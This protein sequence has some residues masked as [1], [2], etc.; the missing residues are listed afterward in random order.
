LGQTR[1]AV[2]IFETNCASIDELLASAAVGA[3]IAVT[4]PAIEARTVVTRTRAVVR[5]T[6]RS[7][8]ERPPARAGAVAATGV[9]VTDA[10]GAAYDLR[11]A[12]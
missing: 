5:R 11:R 7:K 4:V 9:T 6:A 1:R 12:G 8:R 2:T 10:W 3:T